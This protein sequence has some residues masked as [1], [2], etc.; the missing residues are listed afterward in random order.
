MQKTLLQT[1]APQLL[2]Q[3]LK[4]TPE[5][6]PLVNAPQPIPPPVVVTNDLI[7]NANQMSAQVSSILPTNLNKD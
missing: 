3:R 5:H 7:S 4:E 6:S 2:H 1:F